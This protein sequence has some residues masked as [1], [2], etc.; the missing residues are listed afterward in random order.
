MILGTVQFGIPY[1]ISNVHG[2][3]SETEINRILDLACESGISILDT[4]S[5]YG[6]SE[7]LLGKFVEGRFNLI[8]QETLQNSYAVSRAFV[9]DISLLPEYFTDF[10]KIGKGAFDTLKAISDAGTK[11]LSL[12]LNSKKTTESLK[13][14]IE[15]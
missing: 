13:Q 1:G 6:N 14:N 5:L 10:E 11:S 15:I 8:S 2:Q 7:E 12:G 9:G 4:A 3:V